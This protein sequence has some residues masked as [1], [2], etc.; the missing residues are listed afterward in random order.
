MTVS[1]S[2]ERTKGFSH[3]IALSKKKMHVICDE[4]TVLEQK[5]YSIVVIH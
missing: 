2:Q 4:L 3:C 1:E 5:L